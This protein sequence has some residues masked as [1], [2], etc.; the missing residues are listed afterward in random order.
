VTALREAGFDN[1][2][3]VTS[4]NVARAWNLPEPDRRTHV[5]LFVTRASSRATRCIVPGDGQ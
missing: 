4:S 5:A 2:E 3:A 1:I